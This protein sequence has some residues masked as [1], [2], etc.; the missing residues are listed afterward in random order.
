MDVFKDIA[1]IFSDFSS[2]IRFE[3][4][5]DYSRLLSAFLEQQNDHQTA[6][7]SD[8]QFQL[9]PSQPPP[10]Q[11]QQQQQQQFRQPP[12]AAQQQQ[13]QQQQLPQIVVAEYND[14]YLRSVLE[15]NYAR[16]LESYDVKISQR[17]KKR[18]LIISYFQKLFRDREERS[19][20][21]VH[22]IRL[23]TR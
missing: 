13:Q 17:K 18:N 15:N 16:V 9:P 12:P 8:F 5:D 10:Q 6:P 4:N 1:P 11:Q 19:L 7:T 3:D 20:V 2:S 23:R 22:R 14:L 21:P